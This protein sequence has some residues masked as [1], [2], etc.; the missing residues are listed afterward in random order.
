MS[1]N[2]FEL[3]DIPP[4]CPVPGCEHGRQIM[5]RFGGKN[6]YMKTC[7]GHTYLDIP[8]EKAKERDNK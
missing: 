4:P 3:I 7:G 6:H 2:P 1:G 8:A 5:A